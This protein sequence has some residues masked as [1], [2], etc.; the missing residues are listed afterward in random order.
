[1]GSKEEE[2]GNLEASYET[3][4]IKENGEIISDIRLQP[5]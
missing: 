2:T 5:V 4:F 1:M 3:I